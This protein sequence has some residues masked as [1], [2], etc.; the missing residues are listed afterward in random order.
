MVNH[1]FEIHDGLVAAGRLPS[2]AAAGRRISAI[3]LL[4][5]FLCG[6]A[7]AT[8]VGFVKLGLGIP[9]HAIV[10]AVLPMA[11]GL[12]LAPRRFAGSVMS[13]GAFGTAAA[14]S[15]AGLVT[16]GWGALTS[17]CLTGPMMDLAV[18]GA[19]QGPRLYLGLVLSGV[20]AN[21][22]ALASRAVPKLLG[23]DLAGGRPFD[24]WWMQAALTYTLSGAVAGLVG[25]ICWFQFS[26]GRHSEPQ[27]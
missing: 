26:S 8:T 20:A 22:L 7:A 11:L 12:S 27:A 13:A 2:L 1:W 17:L 9:G 25:A 21:L 18:A 15:S 3:E 23:I 19:R 14:L 10:L 6:A 5:L 4:L 24:A 16:F